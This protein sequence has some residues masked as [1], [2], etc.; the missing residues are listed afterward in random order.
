[1]AEDAQCRVAVAAVAVPD[2]RQVELGLSAAEAA[3]Q[4]LALGLQEAL[5]LARHLQPRQQHAGIAAVLGGQRQRFGLAPQ[6]V[7][8]DRLGV[9]PGVDE[10][11]PELVL[12][13]VDRHLA[14]AH[15]ALD[16]VHDEELRFVEQEAVAPVE[17]QLGEGREGVAR[18]LRRI[19]RQRGNTDPVAQE[20]APEVVHARGAQRV[21][22]VG[23]GQDRFALGL[24]PVPHARDPGVVV[25]PARGDQAQRLTRRRARAHDAKGTVRGI[26][27]EMQVRQEQVLV[28]VAAHQPLLVR[29]P[30]EEGLPGL[31]LLALHRRQRQLAFVGRAGLQ[32][33]REGVEL[34][35]VQPGQAVGHAGQRRMARIGLELLDARAGH[36][37]AQR[38]IETVAEHRAGRQRV[39]L[40][41][42]QRLVQQAAREL[43]FGCGRAL[44]EHREETLGAPL[45]GPLRV[46]EQPRRR[47]V[48]QPP[49]VVDRIAAGAARDALPGAQVQLTGRVIAAVADHAT[50]LQDR[51]HVGAPRYG[52]GGRRPRQVV[53]R[54]IGGTEAFIEAVARQRRA[55]HQGT[56]AQGCGQHAHVALHRSGLLGPGLWRWRAALQA[57]VVERHQASGAMALGLRQ[58]T[59]RRAAR[60]GLDAALSRRLPPAPR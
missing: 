58:A 13:H 54:G 30:V 37:P 52:A 11:H 33:A 23:L 57:S 16:E 9:G 6:H 47:G 56:Q 27:L 19:R 7:A 20:P 43:G 36:R 28:Q 21:G 55:A 45:R 34:A 5:L 44:V 22:H 41:E 60:G 18:H 4:H 29:R 3:L 39:L 24:E 17:R 31:H 2:Q 14:A 40:L 48:V 26:G 50:P 38:K 15:R 10:N 35:R 12:D 59:A 46:D 51:L 25:R 32:P 49:G 8:A 53:A 42:P 1:V